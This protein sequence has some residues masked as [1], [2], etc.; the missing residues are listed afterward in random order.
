MGPFDATDSITCSDDLVIHW[1]LWFGFAL[2]IRLDWI[3]K[4]IIIVGANEMVGDSQFIVL[5]LINTSVDNLGS[6]FFWWHL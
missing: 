1:W 3:L 5:Y 6:V 2:T 4:L